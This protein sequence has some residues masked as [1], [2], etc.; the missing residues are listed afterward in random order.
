MSQDSE[1]R[2][3]IYSKSLF[4]RSLVC[5]TKA[6]VTSP[7]GIPRHPS[8]A[9]FIVGFAVGADHAIVLP[10]VY[11]SFPLLSQNAIDGGLD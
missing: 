2:L 6:N 5:A 3:E 9:G 8:D 4:S 11:A 7:W 10:S 1:D